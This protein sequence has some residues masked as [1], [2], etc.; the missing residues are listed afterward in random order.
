M[1]LIIDA[2]IAHELA[3]SP[4]HP[5]AQP[6]IIWLTA[7]AGNLELGGRLSIELHRTRFRRLLVELTRAGVAKIYPLAAILKAEAALRADEVCVSN[8][9]HVLALAIVS[10][11]R[12]LYSRDG[13][14]QKD[15]TSAS[16]INQPR[17]R[18]YSS[19]NH[20][21]LLRQA[22]ACR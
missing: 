10:R 16:V 5:D 3:S 1:C 21:H 8:D 14:L 11:A 19:C 22:P 2:N 20:A 6:V 15:F 9:I 12:V 4:P 18:V 13:N 7:K 17:G